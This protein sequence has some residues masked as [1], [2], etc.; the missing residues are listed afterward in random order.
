MSRLE[1]RLLDDL[2]HE[3]MQREAALDR[4][5]AAD[6]VRAA[7]KHGG[8]DVFEAL[9]RGEATAADVQDASQLIAAWHR[10]EALRRVRGALIRMERGSYGRCIACGAHLP[11]EWLR[12][13]PDAELCLICQGRADARDDDSQHAHAS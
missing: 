1:R 12:A 3:L 2:R 11:V 10:H 4:E 13:E 8:I 6:E 5:V 7:G 9:A